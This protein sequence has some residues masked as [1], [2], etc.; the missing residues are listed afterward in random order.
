MLKPGPLRFYPQRPEAERQCAKYRSF[1][2]R[3]ACRGASRPG[4][5]RDHQV[6]SA[7]RIADRT[8]SMVGS[9]N[10]AF[11]AASPLQSAQL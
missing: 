2:F 5:R 3:H 7:D 10:A 9:R 8:F 1:V 4:R 6:A 11:V